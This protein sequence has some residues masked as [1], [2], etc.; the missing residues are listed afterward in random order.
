M[1]D[2]VY[3]N[4]QTLNLLKPSP[5]CKNPSPRTIYFKSF[6]REENTKINLKI[7]QVT[8]KGHQKEY[9]VTY[10]TQNEIYFKIFVVYVMNQ[11]NKDYSILK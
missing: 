9:F 7:Q 1:P 10:L 11:M 6:E 2:L 5:K 3:H 4:Q 8:L